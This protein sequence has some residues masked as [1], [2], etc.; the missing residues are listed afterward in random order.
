M[1]HIARTALFV[2]LLTSLAA[3]ITARPSFEPDRFTPKK[4]QTNQLYPI[5]EIAMHNVGKID[6]MISNFG[7]FGKDTEDLLLDP[8]SGQYAKSLNYPNNT[9]NTYLWGMRLWIGAIVGRDTLVSTAGWGDWDRA[10][11]FWPD[12]LPNSNIIM[13]SINDRSVAE[14]EGAVSQQDFECYYTDTLDNRELTGYDAPTGRV[15][16]PIGVKVVQRS[17][18]WG[19]DYADDF[20]IFDLNIGNITFRTIE[21]LYI[22]LYVD[23]DIFYENKGSA[24]D[25]IVGF[26][27]TMRSLYIAGLTDTINVAWTAD[28][29]G[30]PN[31][32]TGEYQGIN[33]PTA[34]AGVKILRTPADTVRMNFNWWV[35]DYYSGLNW[36][37]YKRPPTGT[38]IRYFG[39]GLGE[40]RSDADKYFLM[41]NGEIDYD[42]SEAQWDH[43]AD[44]W[45]PPHENID[46]IR[47]GADVHY[48]ISSG[49]FRIKPGDFA[50][51]TFA[52][53]MGQHYHRDWRTPGPT[54]NLTY[55]GLNS[56][57]ASWIFD[58]PG[59]DT[60]G[61]GYKGKYHIYEIGKRIVEIDTLY[62]P[63]G[64]V[65]DTTFA[66]ARVDTLYYEGD[67]VPDFRGAAP[68]PAPD[69]SLHP[70]VNEFN[71][72]IIE[73][74]WNGVK[75]ETE[76]DQFSQFADFEGYR[77]YLSETGHANGFTM[78]ASY[79]VDNYDRWEYDTYNRYWDVMQPPYTLEQLRQMYGAN[80]DPENYDSQAR[81]FSHYNYS[82][83]EYEQYYFTAHDW[84]QSEKTDTTN[85][86]KVY[87]YEPEPPTSDL[88]SARMYWPEVLTPEGRFKYYEYRYIIRDLLPSKSY[89]V[90]VTAFDH[91]DPSKGLGPMETNPTEN[92]GREY[93]QNSTDLVL[94]QGLNVVVYPNP[95][96]INGGYR[97][98][99]EGWEEGEQALPSE[100][101]RA[102]HFSNLPPKCTI[103]IFSID[104][105][106]VA[107]IDH[108]FSPGS[109]GAMHEQWDMISRNRMAIMS[110]IYYYSVESEYGNQ[111]GKFVIIM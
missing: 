34:A 54:H 64:M 105:D 28:N 55:L 10:S 75:S 101:T 58:N 93:A 3:S 69:F 85:I 59:V 106:L 87:P 29:D 108:N 73:V 90:S 110:G 30:D 84:N 53:I 27:R 111:V 44:G 97:G 17:Y 89:Y 8:F 74:R 24:R 80:F 33:S 38:P 107:T 77:V 1:R 39:G 25:D 72:G 47:D 43:S 98:R 66:F 76:P 20:I 11:E 36:G 12:T 14:Y 81:L 67:G 68:P 102:L 60:D 71:E 15:H 88:D 7:I 5:R 103:R 31:P 63:S 35:N 50:P 48:V 26:V 42:L 2:I 92:A 109:P 86:Y 62:L 83:G 19:Y 13:R 37:P 16:R 91:G 41:A 100:F 78:L 32:I 18:A 52:M 95:Y 61:D 70:R 46:R 56:L 94:E 99:Y 51:F 96:Y 22:G 65:I 82:T 40:P 45:L 49:P 23:N 79:D 104:G 21:G 9:L 57:W 6:M 4:A